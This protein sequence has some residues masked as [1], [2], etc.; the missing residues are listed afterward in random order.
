[1]G[2]DGGQSNADLQV[3]LDLT[4]DLGGLGDF[5]EKLYSFYSV[6]SGSSGA[7]WDARVSYSGSSGAR[8][9]TE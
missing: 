8:W 7:S 3:T 5:L 9:G 4:P 1:M 2:L 6:Y